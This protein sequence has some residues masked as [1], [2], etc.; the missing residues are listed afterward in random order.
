VPVRR[1]RD[2]AGA[3]L[4]VIPTPDALD[5]P[6]LR[7]LLDAGRALVGH[8]EL[9]TV[10][11][12]LLETAAD[13]TG[14]RYAALG[15]L[16]ASRQ[17]LERFV[18]HG[19]DAGERAAI[20]APPRGRGVLGALISDP[21]P[22][23]LDAVADDPRSFAFPPGHP[24]MET[25][26][27]VPIL[28]GDEAWGNLYLTDKAGGEPFTRADEDAVVVLAAW[29]AVAIADARLF[30]DS[31]RRRAELE[32]TTAIALAV[33]GDTD[34]GKVLAVIASHAQ[35]LLGARGAAI[36][37]RDETGLA[38]AAASGELPE[39]VQGARVPGGAARMRASLGLP[40][41]DGL[42]V[43]LTFRGR[44]LG[45]LAVSGA[46]TRDERLLR[47]FAASAA[48]AVANARSVEAGR[49]HAAM[50][51]A[52][53][54]RGRWARELHDE[55]LQGLGAL[56]LLLVA[57]RRGDAARL[58][59]GVDGAIER[60][61]AEIDAL[62]GL[63]R[64]L[65]PAA[66]DELG[67]GPAIEGLAERAGVAVHTDVS[68]PG[69]LAAGVETAVYRIVQ[70][71]LNNAVRHAGARRIGLAVRGEPGALVIDVADDGGGFDPTAPTAGFGLA[72]MRERVALLGGELAVDSSPAGTHVVAV[73]PA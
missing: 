50:D 49:L 54:E 27:G 11:E 55:T 70:E 38:V 13:V 33:G 40:A 23:R 29:A 8:L 48:T 18:T 35:A 58:R 44:S 2:G 61:Q 64:E 30:S 12:R 31:E 41:S 60:L 53:A 51:A 16:D 5:E 69:R 46:G 52:E 59:A 17:R 62:R 32:A 15:T 14:A 37:L 1:D 26:L 36:L 43:P 20:G 10:L 71:A 9:D 24:Q 45:M 47:S 67:L 6:T 21:R 19:L 65:R 57:A 28:I 42:L 3:D 66:L 22:L 34:P 63:V 39:A 4:T 56:R 68:L 73:L 25:F 7:R 72:G